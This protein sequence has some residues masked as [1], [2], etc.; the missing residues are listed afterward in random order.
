MITQTQ[1]K[2][3][4]E[5]PKEIRKGSN[6]LN[7]SD[8]KI[9]IILSSPD[10]DEWEFLVDITNNKKKAFKISFHHQEN[11]T[12]EGLLRVDFN[13]GHRN[14]E[15][16]NE[17]VPDFLKTYVSRWFLNEA[18]IHFFVES[19]KDLAW[20]MPLKDY[21]G[22]TTK[23][24]ESTEDYSKAI[25]EFFKHTNIITKFAIQQTIL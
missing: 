7:L 15:L 5:L 19:Y 17:F 10:D 4:I 3:L 6:T 12:N 21:S 23:D 20:A 9:R 13:S 2:Y 24:I 11:N 25:V 16:I 22:F 8:D 14:P 18:H 1:A